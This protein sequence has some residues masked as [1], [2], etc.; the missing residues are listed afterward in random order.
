MPIYCSDIN[1]VSHRLNALNRMTEGIH[2]LKLQNEPRLDMEKGFRD[3][4]QKTIIIC[5]YF[6]STLSFLQPYTTAEIHSTT[7]D[8]LPLD[9]LS[10]KARLRKGIFPSTA[11]P[12]YSTLLKGWES[13]SPTAYFLS[14][15]IVPKLYREVIQLVTRYMALPVFCD[16][17]RVV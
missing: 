14:H 13:S 16:G 4:R 15:V 9:T 2:D 8:L 11:F 17:Q 12:W 5:I 10:R 6:C 7:A 1:H 3:A